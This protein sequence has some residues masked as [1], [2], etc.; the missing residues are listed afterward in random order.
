MLILQ[1]RVYINGGSRGLIVSLSVDDLV[2]VLDAT[3]A[4]ISID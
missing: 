4:N 3:V 2:A 1:P